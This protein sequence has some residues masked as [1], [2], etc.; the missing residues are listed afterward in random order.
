MA[1]R[2]HRD[3]R[4][5][6][7]ARILH[8]RLYVTGEGPIFAA[9][10]RVAHD[11]LKQTLARLDCVPA[12]SMA[13][14][15]HDLGVPVD[16]EVS[17]HLLHCI[18][19]ALHRWRKDL[20]A[21]TRWRPSKRR[22]ALALACEQREI[23]R[24]TSRL[25][26]LRAWQSEL[27]AGGEPAGTPFFLDATAESLLAVALGEARR[28]YPLAPLITWQARLVWWLSGE[29]AT[30]RFLS[31]TTAL[32]AANPDAGLEKEVRGFQQAVMLWNRRSA[33]ERIPDLRKELALRIAELSPEVVRRGRFST[34][35]R[36][37]TFQQH[38][39]RLIKRCSDLLMDAQRRQRQLLPAALAA[40]AAADGSATALPER[41]FRATVEKKGFV[42]LFQTLQG[43]A[44]Q[45]GKPGYD[46][47]LDAV[48][49][50]GETSDEIDLGNLRQ[51]L[52]N[53]NSLADSVWACEQGLGTNSYLSIRASRR[54]SE[55]FAERGCPLAG[56]ELCMLVNR[57]QQKV[58]LVPIHTWLA[59]LGSVSPRAVTPRIRKSLERAFWNTYLPSVQQQGWFDQL[60]AWLVA[61]RRSKNPED[62]QP[63]L[64]RIAAYQERAGRKEALPKSLRKLLAI[65]QHRE[66][67]LVALQ[68]R[69]VAGVLD[70]AALERLRRLRDECSPLPAAGKIRRT[71]EEAFLLLGIDTLTALTR[72]L[73]EA[74][75][76]RHL[77]GLVPFISPDQYW[78]FALWI[79]SM[80]DAERDCLGELIAANRLHG[81]GYKR[82]L[83]DNQS[84][85]RKAL[86]RGIDIDG[87]LAA[88]PEAAM[89]GEKEMEI[90]VA[91]EP[92]DIFLMGN[93][94]RTC[95]SLGGCNELS[96]LANAY[97]ANKQ[98]V[99]IIAEDDRRKRHIVA[100]Q[101]IAVSGD[102]KLLGYRCYVNS[103]YAGEKQH[104]QIQAAVAAYC[105]RLAARCRLQL[106]DQ[107]QPAGI[108]E[109]FWYDDGE[110]EWPAVARAVWA[111]CRST[112]DAA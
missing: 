99:F 109:H 13:P 45:I 108:G 29:C 102:F 80:N 100:R 28:K 10:G 66:R 58:D 42:Q 23:E 68:A 38:C 61:P 46:S 7:L 36:G 53:G 85:I 84:W 50:L 8:A 43:I 83:A 86:G 95:L 21:E 19:R 2:L 91:D 31:A 101:L 105:G 103:H 49:R 90:I 41:R 52:A 4:H 59:W 9:S 34:R 39:D 6:S 78:D 79:A 106:A 89:I 111:E 97:D 32:L 22:S 54:L 5:V 70:Q 93:Y 57:I 62:V 40:L 30:R 3:S 17:G 44:E 71:A 12:S 94:F 1:P 73:A 82:H 67:E 64:E 48:E 92:R 47:L 87:W 37:R 14:T 112:T 76:R 15:P 63:L 11:K 72:Q 77:R 96:V 81:R 18:S 16:G 104:E 20:A 88:Q 55:S 69:A 26:N 75:C 24:L 60:R 107:G 35:L 25:I 51:F 98:V 56:Y 33:D 110:H 27:A 74:K 65:R